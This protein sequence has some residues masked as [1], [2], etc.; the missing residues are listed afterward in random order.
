MGV[1]EDKLDGFADQ[2]ALAQARALADPGEPLHVH[3]VRAL[4]RLAAEPR[5]ACGPAL[6]GA[7][8]GAAGV[9]S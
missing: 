4:A 7:Y 9:R 5:L 2:F 1:H 8:A 6:A 3:V